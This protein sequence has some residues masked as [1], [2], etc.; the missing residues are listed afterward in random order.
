MLK[1]DSTHPAVQ[2]IFADFDSAIKD[3]WFNNLS[4]FEYVI[5]NSELGTRIKQVFLEALYN[6]RDDAKDTLLDRALSHYLNAHVMYL[7]GETC[8]SVFNAVQTAF[9]IDA[10][11]EILTL[12]I[13]DD[14]FVLVRCDGQEYSEHPEWVC[15]VFQVIWQFDV[16]EWAELFISE[17]SDNNKSIL[18][19]DLIY[20]KYNEMKAIN[21]QD[22]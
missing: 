6:L 2:S 17:N 4:E 5:A 9:N 16:H 7:W 19:I 8:E 20:S 3:L 13:G 22:D 10:Y 14:S 11:C 12:H 21:Q 15:K 18:S 1:F